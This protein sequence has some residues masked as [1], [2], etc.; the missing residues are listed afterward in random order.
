MYVSIPAH[1]LHYLSQ[2]L[3][4][5]CEINTENYLE[6]KPVFEKL[7]KENCTLSRLDI[8]FDDESKT[9][10]PR[11]FF[12]FWD[13]RQ[14][15]SPCHSYTF[16]GSKGSTFYVGSRANKI[17]RIYDKTVE[18]D[19]KIDAIRYEIEMHHR[20]ANDVMQMIIDENFN[21]FE[22][23]Q[24]WFVRLKVEAPCESLKDK[25]RLSVLEDLPEWVEF[26]N[27]QNVGFV[28]CH[29][30]FPV[31]GN[32]VDMQKKRVWL[33]R[34]VARTL[35]TFIKSDGID[36]LYD[37]LDDVVLRPVDC[38]IIEDSIRINQITQEMYKRRCNK[39]DIM[40]KIND[41]INKALPC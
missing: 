34:Q 9:F 32:D 1:G 22:L 3:D 29:C 7:R 10:T 2:L 41:E 39:Y 19:G 26:I 16:C 11:D 38:K 4:L 27:S 23:L 28:N 30:V 8:A 25:S 18:S 6:I 13:N 33:R 12:H 15:Q 37:M 20:Y 17:L 35:V 31:H 14:V 40:R 21:F 36:S 24:K 5:D